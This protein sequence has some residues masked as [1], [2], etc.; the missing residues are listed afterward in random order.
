MTKNT[1]VFTNFDTASLEKDDSNNLFK[2]IKFHHAEKHIYASIVNVV[3]STTVEVDYIKPREEDDEEEEPIYTEETIFVV[4]QL[5]DNFQCISKDYIWTIGT[6]ALQEVDRQLQEEK[7][8]RL[9]ME[10]K[11]ESIMTILQNNNLT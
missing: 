8:K 3:D 10:T 4:G 6:A 7:T 1:I 2:M 9:E 5:V 11:L